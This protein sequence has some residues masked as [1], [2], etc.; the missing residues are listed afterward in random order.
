MPDMKRFLENNSAFGR[1]ILIVVPV[2]GL[3]FAAVMVVFMISDGFDLFMIPVLI[4]PFLLF[5]GFCLYLLRHSKSTYLIWWNSL[6]ETQRAE[7]EQDYS[8][9]E[10][11]NDYLILGRKYAYIRRIGKPIPYDEIDDVNFVSVK[12]GWN[13][14]IVLDDGRKMVTQLPVF[15][16]QKMVWAAL[17][18]RCGRDVSY[19]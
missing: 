15:C 4:V 6:T 17:M 9:A 10:P 2:L 14:F 3:L 7:I 5:A 18:E 19:F 12:G 16:N 11:V 1:I 13:M 8:T